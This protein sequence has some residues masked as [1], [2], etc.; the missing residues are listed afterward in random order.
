M[1]SKEDMETIASNFG[2]E[3]FFHYDL[4]NWK[5]IVDYIND[6]PKIVRTVIM[7]AQGYKDRILFKEIMEDINSIKNKDV[8]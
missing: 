3:Y 2:H 7:Q 1:L 4:N 5:Q 6:I 8:K